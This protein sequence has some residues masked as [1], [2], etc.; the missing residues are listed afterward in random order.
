M[1]DGLAA[2]VRAL[3]PEACAG[4]GRNVGLASRL[5]LVDRSGGAGRGRGRRDPPAAARRR[6]IELGAIDERFAIPGG[7]SARAVL[8]EADRELARLRS[9][10][11]DLDSWHRDWPERRREL[12]R[13]ERRSLFDRRRLKAA[14]A[15]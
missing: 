1:L 6:P 5:A 9:G 14:L 7:E 3:R 2:Y 12:L 11:G 10:G 8:R 4:G 13:L 15:G